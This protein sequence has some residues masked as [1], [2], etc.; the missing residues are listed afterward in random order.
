METTWLA[1]VEVLLLSFVI[2]RW[3]EDPLAQCWR[4]RWVPTH[5]THLKGDCPNYLTCQLFLLKRKDAFPP[6]HSQLFHSCSQEF[7]T[8]CAKRGREG[9]YTH[10]LI[11]S[12]EL[13]ACSTRSLWESAFP[14]AGGETCEPHRSLCSRSS[15]QTSGVG[16]RIVRGC[17]DA[18]G[19]A[20]TYTSRKQPC[21]ALGQFQMKVIYSL[22]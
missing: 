21:T 13:P 8:H 3:L 6:F 5:V 11:F 17:A 18:V 4:S 19:L 10:W 2:S 1:A 12:S 20:P 14:G 16:V 22:F 9:S 7:K 15:V